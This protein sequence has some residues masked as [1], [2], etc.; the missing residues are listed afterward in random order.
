MK[1]VFLMKPGFSRA[2]LA[3][4]AACLALA[5][6]A[7][8]LNDNLQAMQ[9]TNQEAGASQQRILEAQNQTQAM[10]QEYK[11]LTQTVDFQDEHAQALQARVTAQQKEIASLREQLA[12][13]QIT[14]Q[15]IEPLMR[16]MADTLEQFVA[17]DLPFHAEER[18]AR[19]VKVK[20]QLARTTLPLPE[21]YRALLAAYQQE[22]EMSNTLEAWR[23]DLTLGEETLTVEFLRIGRVALYFQTMDGQRSGYWDRADKQWL[24]LPRDHGED[25]KHGLRLARNQLAPQLLALPLKLQGGAQ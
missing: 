10:A 1:L 15:R 20:E 18:M 23:G 6:G 9:A 17:L 2:V 13:R 8:T 24:E 25:I 11:R 3:A 19:V 12:N 4:G 7:A 21:K 5:A 14:Q 16:S 22:L